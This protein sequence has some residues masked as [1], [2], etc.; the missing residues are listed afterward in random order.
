MKLQSAL[1]LWPVIAA[2]AATEAAAAAVWPPILL[3]A[4]LLSICGCAAGL[5]QGTVSADS[6]R[7]K[8]VY[9]IYS[10][11]LTNPPTHLPDDNKRYLIAAT[12]DPLGLCG[13]PPKE[14]EA[15]YRE[16]LRDYN[17]RQSIP[18]KL[19]PAFSI[20][21]PYL[22]LSA[23]DVKKFRDEY[24]H[25][26]FGIKTRSDPR[27]QGVRHL[28]TLS[29]VYFNEHGTLAVTAI[30]S[31]CGQFCSYAEWKVFEKQET[32][33][34]EERQPPTCVMISENVSRGATRQALYTA[35]G[36]IPLHISSS[37]CVV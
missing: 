29:D 34:W 26:L 5:P 28:F 7:E 36:K 3:R 14:R 4:L 18:R 30:S 33:E 6:D 19:K 32:G 16:I 37:A 2:L 22:L 24:Y 20:R 9:A 35:R 21:K 31:W 11:M 27:F 13:H 1:M 17:H 8:D 12:T 25:H 23:D 10:L 15:E